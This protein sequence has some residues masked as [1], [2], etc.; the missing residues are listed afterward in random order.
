VVFT[1]YPIT[2]GAS[3]LFFAW[4]L[5]RGSWLRDGANTVL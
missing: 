5:F 1:A 4:F 3:C 2:W